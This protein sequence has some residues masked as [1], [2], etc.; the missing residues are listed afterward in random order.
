MNKPAFPTLGGKQIKGKYLA[1]DKATGL[2]KTVNGYAVYLV[3]E[4]NGWEVERHIGG[5]VGSTTTK[6]GMEVSTMTYPHLARVRKAIDAFN[7]DAHKKYGVN[8]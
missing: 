5:F 1:R 8:A 3:D 2:P 7:R 4:Y 6:E